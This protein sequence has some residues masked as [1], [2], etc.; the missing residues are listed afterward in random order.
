MWSCLDKIFV[1]CFPDVTKVRIFRDHSVIEWALNPTTGALIRGGKK[2]TY[3]EMQEERPYEEGGR[4]WIDASTCQGT[5]GIADSH[6]KLREKPGTHSPSELPERSSPSN[7]LI[8]NYVL[9]NCEWINFC[10]F[11]P[12]NLW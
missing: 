1:V 9:R 4:D 10:C 8:L 11:K 12:P 7:T 5:P 6:R 2:R 3:T